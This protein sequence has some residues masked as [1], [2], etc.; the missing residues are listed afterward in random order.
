MSDFSRVGQ[1]LQP[2]EEELRGRLTTYLRVVRTL[3]ASPLFKRGSVGLIFT[4][5]GDGKFDVAAQAPLNWDELRGALTS[6]RRLWMD[7]EPTFF[8]RL[9]NLLRANAC[10]R[11]GAAAQDLVDWL[12]ALGKEFSRVKAEWPL[13][14]D[15]EQSM[16]ILEGHE[17]GGQLVDDGLVTPER[18][19]DDWFNGEVFHGKEKHRRRIDAAGDPEAYVLA[20]MIAVQEVT[21]VY[22]LLARLAKA[23]LDEPSLQ[24]TATS[25]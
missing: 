17:D 15:G 11:G 13:A 21:R 10:A 5:R 1:A 24:P 2:V 7:G 18:V 4:P 12:D 6:L 16:A 23:I 19:I 8:S 22:V 20:L 14:A 3:T 9:R 25:S